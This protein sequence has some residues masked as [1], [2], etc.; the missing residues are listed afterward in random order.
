M[1]RL[2]HEVWPSFPLYP[3]LQE[4]PKILQKSN[5][6][7]RRLKFRWWRKGEIKE[8]GAKE[9]GKKIKERTRIEIGTV[10]AN[11][12]VAHSVTST[13]LKSTKDLNGQS[14]KFRFLT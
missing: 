7:L 3:Q 10:K 6:E 13:K 4:I 1:G 8:K 14:H 12:A 11:L 2:R 9:I 5:V